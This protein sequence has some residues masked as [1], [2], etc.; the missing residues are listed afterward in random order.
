MKQN[1]KITV[2]NKGLR[3]SAKGRVRQGTGSE[4]I[5]LNKYSQYFKNLAQILS[6][7]LLV[8]NFVRLKLCNMS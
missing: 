1:N 4:R 6:V 7:E 3:S 5:E 8:S 2:E